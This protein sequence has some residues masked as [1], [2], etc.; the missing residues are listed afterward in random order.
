MSQKVFLVDKWNNAIF[1]GERHTRQRE[2]ENAGVITDVV[3]A[4]QA[5]IDV[6]KRA[7][8]DIEALSDTKKIIYEP[9]D[10][11]VAFEFRV[12]ADGNNDDALAIQLLAEAGVDHYTKVADFVCDQGQQDGDGTEHFIDDMKTSNKDW[13]TDL[14]VVNP[15]ADYIA[16]CVLNTHG[17]NKFLWVCTDL[18]NATNLYIDVRRTS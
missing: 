8:A 18:Q 10:G 6:D 14:R 3:A 15:Q 7:D 13:E 2:W 5:P 1:P 17:H 9:E 11:T 4:G 16:R 12:R